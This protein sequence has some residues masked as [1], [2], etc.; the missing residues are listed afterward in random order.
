MTSPASESVQE[1]T[2]NPVPR[3]TEHEEALA[4]DADT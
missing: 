3:L 1:V 4:K 2:C